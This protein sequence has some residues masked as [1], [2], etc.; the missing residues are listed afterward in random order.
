IIVTPLG[1]D[2]FFFEP[3]ER[4]SQNNAKPFLLYVGNRQVYKNFLRLLIAFGQ[5]GLA[6]EFD[7]RLI[8][9]RGG[10]LS[11]QEVAF[12][13]QYRLQDS[14][15]LMTAVSDRVLHESYAGA[16]VFVYPS[17]YEGFG[18]PVLEAMASGTLVALSD[19]SSLPEVGGD[20]GFY[21]DPQSID[22][23]ADC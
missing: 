23:I 21:F 11:P 3:S 20:V 10:G 12:I 9:P 14:V 22:S 19:V 5:S 15:Q 16:T 17:E 7:L 1:V 6:R 4:K 18:L 2:P 13:E 8:S